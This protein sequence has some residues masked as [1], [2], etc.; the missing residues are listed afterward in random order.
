MTKEKNLINTIKNLRK[1]NDELKEK[2]EKMIYPCDLC[3]YA[4][5]VDDSICKSC[6]AEKR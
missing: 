5:T 3:K 2:I 4:G 1:Q 6:P